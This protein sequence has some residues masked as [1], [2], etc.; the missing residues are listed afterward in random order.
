MS[1]NDIA[2]V[3]WALAELGVVMKSDH[4]LRMA[5]INNSGILSGAK[6]SLG[7]DEIL[8]LAEFLLN[9]LFEF[10]PNDSLELLTRFAENVRIG[11]LGSTFC[12][13]T[14]TYSPTAIDIA[15]AAI[16]AT[17]AVMRNLSSPGLAAVTPIIKLAVETKPSFPPRT[18]ARNQPAR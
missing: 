8:E 15:P 3:I 7:L 1:A 13:F 16:A 6:L 2:N 4:S 9:A 18:A 10:T 11:N 12:D 17:P 14:E 5:E